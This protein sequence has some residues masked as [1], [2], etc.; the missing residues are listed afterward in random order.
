MAIFNRYVKL[1]EGSP[2][3]CGFCTKSDPFSGSIGGLIPISTYPTC[4]EQ[5]PEPSVVLTPGCFFQICPSPSNQTVSRIP[6]SSIMFS[7]ICSNHSNLH[8]HLPVHRQFLVL[9]HHPLKNHSS[10]LQKLGMPSKIWSKIS[11]K[12]LGSGKTLTVGKS[13]KLMGNTWQIFFELNPATQFQPSDHNIDSP[14]WDRP[15]LAIPL[16]KTLHR[17][18]LAD[19]GRNAG[20]EW[21][22]LGGKKG[23]HQT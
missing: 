18:L 9:F 14:D 19:L 21:Q 12:S 17:R 20:P 16:A 3:Y 10:C 4:P 6:V 8:T 22:P 11:G 5:C 15:A 1:P 2:K 23:I 7:E 13:W